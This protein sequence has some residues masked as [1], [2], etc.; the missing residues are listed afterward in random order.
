MKTL[1]LFTSLGNF[2]TQEEYDEY[3]KIP[4]LDTAEDD[5]YHKGVAALLVGYSKVVI[6]YSDNGNVDKC[7]YHR[8]EKTGTNHWSVLSVAVNGK[9]LTLYGPDFAPFVVVSA[10]N[11][12]GFKVVYRN[13]R[14][15]QQD[16]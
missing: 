6:I 13:D 3:Q 8:K 4:V 16:D 5:M 15:E 9:A 1:T 14:K 12:D 2:N 10:D 7:I 11:D